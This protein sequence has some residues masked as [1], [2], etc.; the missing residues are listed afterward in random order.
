VASVRPEE[1]LAGNGRDR[2]V[3]RLDTV[4]LTH[5]RWPGGEV[6]G[7]VGFDEAFAVL[8]EMR[9]QGRIEHVG[10]S[11]VTFDQLRRSHAKHPVASVSNMFSYTDQRDLDV[12]EFCSANGIP[13]LPYGPLNFGSPTAAVEV[14][15]LADRFGI[16]P[17][18]VMIVWL[19]AK[20]PTIVPIPGTGSLKHLEENVAAAAVDAGQLF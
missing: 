5:L 15:R 13:Y 6:V 10:L 8:V 11:N 17:A 1:L 9:A 16:T 12:V 20:S 14:S 19:L 18:Q 3:L 2:R 7:G 4:P